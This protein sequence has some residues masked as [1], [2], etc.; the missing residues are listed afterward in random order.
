VPHAAV[1]DSSEALDDPQA[2]HLRLQTEATHPEMGRFRSVRFPAQFDGAPITDIE[3]PPTLGE[4]NRAGEPAPGWRS[5][6]S[7]TE[8]DHK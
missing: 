3:A 2:L 4:H 8:L 7:D 1:Y 5:H 6:T